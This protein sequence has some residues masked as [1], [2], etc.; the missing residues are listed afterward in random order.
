MT[1]G[2]AVVFPPRP[3]RPRSRPPPLLWP[4]KCDSPFFLALAALQSIG[5]LAGVTLEDPPALTLYMGDLIAHDSEN[6]KSQ[7]Y[8]EAV[9]AVV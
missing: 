2:C 8:V 9:E 5:P 6:Q 4:Y 3:T 7:G 1:A